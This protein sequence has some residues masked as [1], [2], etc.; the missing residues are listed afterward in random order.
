L[1]ILGDIFAREHIAV[2]VVERAEEFKC[3]APPRA[4]A[5]GAS[6][7]RL[8]GRNVQDARKFVF[9]LLR[10]RAW[11]R[12]STHATTKG[13]EYKSPIYM[14][15]LRSELKNCSIW[16]RNSMRDLCRG[17]LAHLVREP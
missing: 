17:R 16:L 9:V 3:S 1:R 12:L 7:V 8:L 4:L 6:F 15:R 10:H 2:L 13:R 14:Q 5:V 11:I